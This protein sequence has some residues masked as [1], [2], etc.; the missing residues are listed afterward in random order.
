[1]FDLFDLAW[2][3]RNADEHGA[4]LEIQL[5]IRLPT[6]SGLLAIFITLAT[7]ESLPVH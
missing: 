7:G 2:R 6:A 5:M 3:L 4:D 1:M